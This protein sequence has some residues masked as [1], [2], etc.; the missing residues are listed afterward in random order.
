MKI[1]FLTTHMNTGGITSYLLTLSGGLVKAGHQVVVVS[2]GGDC[3]AALERV[4]GRHYQFDIKVKSEAHPK[5]WLAL[6]KLLDVVKR[7]QINIIHAQTRVT[8]V[9]GE[10]ISAL[11][12]VPMLSTCHGFFRP[13]FFRRILPCWGRSVIAISRPVEEHLLKDF[14]LPQ[15]KVCFI[16][17]GIEVAQFKFTTPQERQLK[18]QQWRITA[19]PVIGIIA[20]LSVVKGIDTLLRAMPLVLAS[21]PTAQ[22]MIV[23]EGPDKA[24]L[25]GIAEELGLSLHVRFDSIVNQTADILG[26]FDVFVMPSL[27]EGLGLSVMEAQAAGIA[28]I[29][30]NVGGLPDLVKDGHTGFLVKPADA[31]ALAQAIVRMLNNPAQAQLMAKQARIQVET[32]FDSKEMTLQVIKLYEEYTRC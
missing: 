22:L 3:V 6:P 32:N 26:A 9:I 12:K 31:Q 25:Q 30:S 7:E 20:R 21:L 24:R 11:T 17:N 4:G 1:L 27:Q 14:H 28:V 2:S 16:P 23:G 5:L 8:Q 10:F 18:R 19:D 13:R 15:A 29:A